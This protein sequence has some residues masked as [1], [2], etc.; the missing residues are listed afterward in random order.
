MFVRVV[1]ILFGHNDLK[2]LKEKV[3]GSNETLS[4]S[5]SKACSSHV[6]HF[7]KNMKLFQIFPIYRRRL[8]LSKN[9]SEY[10]L[11]DVVLDKTT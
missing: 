4:Y 11:S 2:K 10:E 9:I 5:I 3:L 6:L 8:N 1:G 7:P